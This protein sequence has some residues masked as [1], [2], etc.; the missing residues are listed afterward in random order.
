MAKET[1]KDKYNKADKKV[2]RIAKTIGAVTAIIIAAMGV[3]SWVS[4]QFQSAVSAQIADFRQETQ[5]YDL[6]HEQAVT[7]V[8]LM[9][10]MEHDP[11]NK[12]AIERMAKYYLVDL[13]GD[14]YM[15]EKYSQW[16]DEHDGDISFLV[17]DKHE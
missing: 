4:N 14:R 10:L 2:Q 1:L 3:C 7:R 9:M 6:R 8:E 11:D 15:E 5:E 12:V 17:G 16:A 13:S